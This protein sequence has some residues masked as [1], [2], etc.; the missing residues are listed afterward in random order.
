MTGPVWELLGA[1]L[2]RFECLRNRR[3]GSLDPNEFMVLALNAKAENLRQLGDK[4]SAAALFLTAI[5]VVGK[6]GVSPNTEAS[7]YTNYGLLLLSIGK[8]DQAAQLQ[9]RALKLDQQVGNPESL[10]YSHHNLGWTLMRKGEYGEAIKHLREARRIRESL[11]DYGELLNTLAALAEV[12]L[13][14][15]EYE[16]AEACAKA[17]LSLKARL[18]SVPSLR[19]VLSVLARVEVYRKHWKRANSLY[20]EIIELLEILRSNYT[21]L[22]RLDLFD[23]RYNKYY[24]QAI[25]YCL[26]AGE[27]RAALTLID[28]TR[29]RS[30]CDALEGTRRYS[31]P[32][33][34]NVL[35]LPRLRQGELVLVNWIY[36]KTDHSF[37][38]TSFDGFSYKKTTTSDRV[39]KP[40][41]LDLRTQWQDHSINILRQAQRGLD[42]FEKELKQVHRIIFIPH[43]ARWQVPFSGLKHPAT[44]EPLLCSHEVLL[45]PSLRYCIIT[46]DKPYHRASQSLVVGDPCDDLPSARR[47]AEHIAAKL[48]C[49][50]LLGSAATRAAVL[51]ALSESTLDVAHFSCHGQFDETGTQGLVLADGLLTA[52]DIA[53]SRFAANLVNLASCWSG[54]TLFSVWTELEGFQRRLLIQGIRNVIS[55]VYPIDDDAA[56]EFNRAFY[57]AYSP[58]QGA[59]TAFQIAIAKISQNPRLEGWEGLHITG[60]R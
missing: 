33:R 47:E 14:S 54:M 43:G 13:T 46:D 44:R 35:Q 10:G 28:R 1:D 5:Q 42:A 34:R 53:A 52:K 18:G 56:F 2:A 3:Y 37:G 22:D 48:D 31:S 23:S 39:G 50:A 21:E 15:D 57:G 58:G 55:S 20:G 27:Y 40:I 30:G 38:L 12:H 25:E 59:V 17:G 7:L 24:E 41:R 51:G 45:M 4:K 11:Q 6:G 29:F 49:N 16:E 60:Q 36:P 9:S 8:V 26:E 19:G 32:F